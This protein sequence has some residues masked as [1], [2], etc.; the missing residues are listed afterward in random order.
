MNTRLFSLI[1]TLSASPACLAE[2]V[3][4]FRGNLGVSKETNLPVRW[5]ASEGLRW[6][7]NLPG[8]G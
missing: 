3:T 1:L 5:S 2:D 8:K 6:K 4:Q 7:A